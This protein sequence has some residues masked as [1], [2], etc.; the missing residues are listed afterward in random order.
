[1]DCLRL[2][3]QNFASDN[4][5]IS[6]KFER[7]ICSRYLSWLA[8]HEKN[9]IFFIKRNLEFHNALYSEK[10]QL[11]FFSFWPREVDT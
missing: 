8:V 1:M 7:D 3:Y 9:E 4:K 10:T 6:P 11:N 2:P 5:K